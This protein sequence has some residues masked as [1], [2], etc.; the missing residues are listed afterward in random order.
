MTVMKRILFLLLLSL[1]LQ[2]SAGQIP[3]SQLKRLDAAIALRSTYQERKEARI[4]KLH[5][6]LLEASTLS[7]KIDISKR[8][9]HEYQAYRN[10]TAINY[11]Q[12]A[13]EF[14]K[15]DNDPTEEALLQSM[16]AYQLARSGYYGTGLLHIKRVRRQALDEEGKREY[17]KSLLRTKQATR[18]LLC[19]L[20]P[21]Q[22]LQSRATLFY[23]SL[24]QVLPRLTT[25]YYENQVQLLTAQ[26][27][28]G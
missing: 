23:D 7:A 26:Q 24:M 5:D 13:I 25:S 21:T 10:E 6:A 28:H 18:H 8:L 22:G 2:I 27:S 14:A 15:A 9:Y 19:G 1:P 17:F 11:L 16:L 20:R 12:Q 3:E 4:T